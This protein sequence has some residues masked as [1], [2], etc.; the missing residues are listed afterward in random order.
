MKNNVI[1]D[2]EATLTYLEENRLGRSK[3]Q[4]YEH[5]VDFRSGQQPSKDHIRKMSLVWP[6]ID[7]SFESD[8]G[9]SMIIYNAHS[10]SNRGMN[11]SNYD[12]IEASNVGEESPNSDSDFN[13][14]AISNTKV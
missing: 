7:S 13:T 3:N 4:I 11:D 14:E 10:S 6:I 5:P 8:L 9:S 12:E 1:Q 2:L